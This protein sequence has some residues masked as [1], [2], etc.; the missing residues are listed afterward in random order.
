MRIYSQDPSKIVWTYH[1]VTFS[2]FDA[3]L[4][5]LRGRRFQLCLISRRSRY[6]A[7]TRFFRRGI[8]QKGHVANF[9][10]TEQLLLVEDHQ[11]LGQVSSGDFATKMSFVQVRGS[12][13]VFWAE[14]NTLRYK[15][16]L[17]IMDLPETVGFPPFSFDIMQLTCGQADAMRRHLENLIS[18][19]GHPILVNL[20]NQK[21]HEKPI[22]EAYER[23][24]DQVRLGLNSSGRFSLMVFIVK[25]TRCPI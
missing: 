15:P 2:A 10:E 3:R 1:G 9:V 25:L 24:I 5:T 12:I 19:Y 18:L 23:Y 8:D 11:A 20:V 17:Q 7:G 13:P 6:R 4:G 14:V 16:D 22:K 21:G